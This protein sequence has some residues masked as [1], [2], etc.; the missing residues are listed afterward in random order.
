[1]KR[2]YAIIGCGAVGALYGAWLA[3]AGFEVHFLARSDHD[4]IRVH[5]LT[6]ESAARGDFTIPHVNVYSDA[7][8]MPKCDVAAITLKTTENRVL[9]RVLPHVIK[10]NGTVLVMQNGLGFE[11]RVAALAGQKA[12]LG[13][14][15]FVC[16]NKVGPGHVRHLDFGH[17]TIGQHR[18]SGTPA[19]GITPAMNDIAADFAKAGVTVGLAPDLAVARW[20]KLVWNVPYNGLSVV[21]NALTDSLMK[22]PHSLSMVKHLM[23]E[24]CAGAAAC[25]HPIEEGFIEEMLTYTDSM[26]PYKTS[27]KIDFDAKRPMEVE[28]IFGAP[29]EAAK[30]AGHNLPLLSMLYEELMYLEE[31][32][33]TPLSP[34]RQERG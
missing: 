27:M 18:E 9:P 32:N 31:L 24:V 21:L 33:L 8:A 10:D 5:G 2:T 12:V 30:K 15:C 20:K 25:G 11:E 23:Q 26:T 17:V 13:V 14:L 34:L 28:S 19:A 1:V 22:N 7:S 3:R 29:L 6:I 16:S 4:Y